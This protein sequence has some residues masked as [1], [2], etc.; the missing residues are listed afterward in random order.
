MNWSERITRAS[1]LVLGVYCILSV[2]SGF[3]RLWDESGHL[4]TL[5]IA[6]F[7]IV[8]GVQLIKAS[9]DRRGE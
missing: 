9:Y 4:T 5:G 6:A 1:A 7:L 2:G 8:V 3:S